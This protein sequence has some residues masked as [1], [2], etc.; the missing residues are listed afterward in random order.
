MKMNKKIIIPL[1]STVAGL[2]LIGGTSG[3]VAWYQYNTRATA[4]FVGSSV[5]DSGVL[6]IGYKADSESPISWGRDVYE[7]GS[8]NSNKL[9][10]V[11]FGQMAENNV[12]PTTAYGYPEAG[13]GAYELWSAATKG[14]EYI[15]YDIYLKAQQADAS[16]A[17]GYKQVA[18]DVYITDMVLDGVTTGKEAIQDALRVH[19]AVEGGTNYLISRT[20]VTDLALSGNLDLDADGVTDKEGGYAWSVDKDTPVVYGRNGEKQTTSGIADIRASRNADGDIV[21]QE[22]KK[23]CTTPVDG[24]QKIT[25]TVWLEGWQTYGTP[26]SSIWNAFT[27]GDATVNVGMTFDVGRN[28]FKQ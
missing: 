4:S 15:Q 14:K 19:L 7:T 12:L 13:K 22:A 25:I 1:F 24:Q 11:T 9:S 8:T 26:A 6:Q 2:S 20:K 27:T 23:I 16:Q 5:A 10:P 21:G 17:S 3:A 28:A 18:K